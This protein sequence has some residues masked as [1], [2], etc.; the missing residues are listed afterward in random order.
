MSQ[1]AN[2]YM[3]LAAQVL[4]G[5]NARI[6]PSVA[7]FLEGAGDLQGWDAAFV[8]VAYA[9]APQPLTP[10]GH[11]ARTPY[12]RPDGFVERMQESVV[13]GWLRAD[14]EQF[15]LTD[16]GREVAAEIFALGDRL[17]AKIEALPAPE[18]A[19]LS[20]L[21]DGVTQTIQALPEPAEKPTFAF[22]ALFER[23]ASAPAIV[24]VRRRMID[25]LGFRDDVHV[26]AWQAH[27][28]DGHLIETFTL[29]WRQ[30]A[31]TA[32]A[33]AEQLPYRN[34]DEAAYAAALETLATRGWLRKENTHYVAE[35]KGIQIREQIEADTD[36][37]FEAAFAQLSTTELA[38][39]Q[40][41]LQQFAAAVIPPENEND[42][43]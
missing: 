9:L 2:W 19:R 23:P 30:Q 1:S 15:W 5:L 42:A 20:A 11:I 27:E 37:L 43:T 4:G 36:Q 33:L 32:A 40:T 3:D 25:I 21:L 28:P 10:G 29:V 8:Q 13:R 38:E 7:T 24:H 18:M 22:G 41:L 35:E 6:Q 31:Q 34:Y 16:A 39:L 14:G 17:F 12:A 26:A